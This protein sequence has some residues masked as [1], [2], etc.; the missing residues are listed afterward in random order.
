M[1]PS[2]MSV[3]CLRY[4]FAHII[5]RSMEYCTRQCQRQ[6]SVPLIGVAAGS[7]FPFWPRSLVKESQLTSPSIVPG[8]WHNLAHQVA[9]T[10]AAALATRPPLVAT[11]HS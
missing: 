11:R 1:G 2:T 4:C 6:G 8:A 3:L 7:Q 9:A 10:K 5:R